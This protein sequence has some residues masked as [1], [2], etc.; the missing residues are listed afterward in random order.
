MTATPDTPSAL[1]ATVAQHLQHYF[2][3]QNVAI[4]SADLYGHILREV[5]RPLLEMTLAQC[6]GNQIKAAAMLGLN[7]N[8][9][10]KKIRQLGITPTRKRR[11]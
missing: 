1:S 11:G 9:L 10:R 3:T 2:L 8:T 4:S 5:E 7:R 6:H